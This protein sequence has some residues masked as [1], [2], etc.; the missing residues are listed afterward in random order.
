M[1]KSATAVYTL[2]VRAMA[3]LRR[4]FGTPAESAAATTGEFWAAQGIDK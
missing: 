2:E 3:G 4:Y 1:G